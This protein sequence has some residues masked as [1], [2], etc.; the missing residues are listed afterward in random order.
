M[1]EGNRRSRQLLLSDVASGRAL[2]LMHPAL[3]PMPE[4]LRPE[5]ERGHSASGAGVAVGAVAVVRRRNSVR[6]YDPGAP[7]AWRA[8]SAGQSIDLREHLTQARALVEADWSLTDVV[9]DGTLWGW[10]TRLALSS[11]VGE[12][13]VN[14]D[15]EAG[16]TAAERLALVDR[17]IGELDETLPRGGWTVTG[18]DK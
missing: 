5:S 18:G 16:R 15:Q 1:S 14:W 13:L 17:A 2:E 10:R 6:G 3:V 9:C 4:E 11:V 12:P 8:A 7:W